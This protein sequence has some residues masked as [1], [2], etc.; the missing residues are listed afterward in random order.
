MGF[1]H[2][3][4]GRENPTSVI[5]ASTSEMVAVYVGTAPVVMAKERNI[6]NPVLCYSYDEAVEQIGYLKDFENY[7]LCEAIDSHF[8][9]FGSGP[10]VLI[11][12]LNPEIHKADIESESIRKENNKFTIKRTGVIPETVRIA[13]QENL[14]FK[15][16]DDGYLVIIG[17]L[18]GDSITVSY[19]YLNPSSITNQDIIGGIDSSTGMEKGLE[20]IENIFP[21]FRVIPNLILAPK[22]SSDSAVAAVMETKA[23]K[24]N[25]HFQGLA[26]VDIDT[27]TVKKYTDVPGIKESNNLASTFM[28][29]AWPKVALGESQYHMSTQIACIIQTLAAEN[30]GI[31]FKSPSNKSLKA[32][33][34][35]LND[36]TPVLLGVNKANYLNSNGI[37]TPLNFIGGWKAWGN[38][39][40]CFPAVTD[41]KDAFIASR[42]M[43]NFLNNT[44]VTTFWQKVDEATNQVLINTIVDSC[45]IWLNGL[46]NQGQILGGRIEFR[47]A[48]NP[49][50]SLIAGKITLRIYFTPALP[51]QEIC[52]LKEIDVKYFENIA[53]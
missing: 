47:A 48:D 43:F 31:P 36:R 28:L 53:K 16:D 17:E 52:F 7:T 33:S 49:T 3:V 26:L 6:N 21:K 20:C 5:A 39:T 25:G 11:N 50:T 32:D 10:I 12:V 4:T 29:V 24:I 30:S 44:L 22:F 40:A 45:N 37:I 1:E 42:L 13:G 15:F 8:S 2:G 9:K 19:S 27:K 51:A 18:S 46:T 23:K 41:P 34:A 14:N 38:N 35:I